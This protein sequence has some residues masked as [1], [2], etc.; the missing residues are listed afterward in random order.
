MN[1]NSMLSDRTLSSKNNLKYWSSLAI[2]TDPDMIS[3]HP[4]KKSS[5]E[6]KKRERVP[7]E[8]DAGEEGVYFTWRQSQCM[9]HFLDGMTQQE[10][11][12]LL[13]ISLR[14]IER[15]TKDM[16]LKLNC[17]DKGDLIHTVAKTAFKENAHR[18]SQQLEEEF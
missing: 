2:L 7:V 10:V 8:A 12:R 18:V 1:M 16:C 3:Y 13:G 4:E 14:T 5:A 11:A 15:Y 17:R 6:K 9:L